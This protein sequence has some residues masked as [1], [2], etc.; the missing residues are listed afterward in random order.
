MHSIILLKK[1]S[2]IRKKDLPEERNLPE[3]GNS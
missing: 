2:E 1:S 3:T